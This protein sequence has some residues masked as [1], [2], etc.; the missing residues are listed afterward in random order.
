VYDEG[1]E[2]P[3]ATRRHET[4][5]WTRR[6]GAGGPTFQEAHCAVEAFGTELIV[7]KRAQQFT[8]DNVRRFR[9]CEGS[10]V[11]K[12]EADLLLPFGSLPLLQAGHGLRE[13]M[14]V[15]LGMSTVKLT[16][17][18]RWGSSRSRIRMRCDWRAQWRSDTARRE[19]P[20]QL[21]PHR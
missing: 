6:M 1:I 9:K 18:R 12:Q 15:D 11:A 19:G 13:M 8:D 3:F 4:G 16:L 2:I 20:F 10:H 5:Q 21:P 7:S 17:H 14:E